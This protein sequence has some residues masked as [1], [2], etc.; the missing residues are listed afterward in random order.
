MIFVGHSIVLDVM[1]SRE[2]PYRPMKSYTDGLQQT[3][4][5]NADYEDF[6]NSLMG[7]FWAL[8]KHLSGNEI[9]IQFYSVQKIWNIFGKLSHEITSRGISSNGEDRSVGSSGVTHSK[10]SRFHPNHLCKMTNT[11]WKSW[12][13]KIISWVIN[14]IVPLFWV[15]KND[16]KSAVETV[17][18]LDWTQ[19]CWVAHG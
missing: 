7:P 6:M 16:R 14:F 3:S 19:S 17:V 5:E 9:I 18:I 15:R 8:Y 12:V 11:R 4:E 13:G 10:F 1:F 2:N